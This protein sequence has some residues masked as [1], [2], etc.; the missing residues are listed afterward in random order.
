MTTVSAWSCN[1]GM[2]LY[3]GSDSSVPACRYDISFHDF[4]PDTQSL[5][6]GVNNWLKV[7]GGTLPNDTVRL[8]YVSSDDP[9]ASASTIAANTTDTNDGVIHLLRL[10]LSTALAAMSL[11][12]RV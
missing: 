2:L 1:T 11:I 10:F 8:W 4:Q 12:W 6:N 3:C 7:T 5:I 9:V